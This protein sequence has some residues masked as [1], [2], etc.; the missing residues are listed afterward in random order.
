MIRHAALWIA[1]LAGVS[2][3]QVL[4][5]DTEYGR[6]GNVSLKLDASIPDGEGPFPV[7]IAV[8]GGGWGSGDK[9]ADITPLFAPLTDAKFTWFSINYR[10]APAH[11]W[12]A[13]LD[14]V[15]T[16][17]GWVKAHA[18]EY[19]GDPNRVALIGYSAG[20][21]LAFMATQLAEP[22]QR[23]QALVGLAP[24][25]DFE[26]DLPQ[27][28]GLSKALQ[29]LLDRPKDVDETSLKLIREIG[30]IHHIKKDLPPYLLLQGTADKTV[31]LV[32]TQN[33]A[34]KLREAGIACDI[35]TVEG[36]PHRFM[37][38]GKFDPGYKTKLIDWL[39]MALR[40]RAK[41]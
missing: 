1:L 31:P 24:P 10:L 16:A 2:S 18:A 36:A 17:V 35:V 34:A 12:P 27:R 23:V 40:T 25:T 38:W 33:F 6:A 14:D 22:S 11:R 8:H 21:H 7:A 9:A 13:C 32:Q 4:R 15:R 20:G 5:T 19:K 3:A 39:T 41:P 26:Q 30:P 28:G 37:D 29:D